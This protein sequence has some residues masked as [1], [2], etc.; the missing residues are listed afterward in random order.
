M[1]VRLR[2]IMNAF[3]R[4]ERTS[5]SVMSE[6]RSYWNSIAAD[7]QETAERNLRLIVD[8]DP[9]AHPPRLALGKLLMQQERTE[10]GVPL[11]TE[12][13]AA[14][15]AEAAFYLGVGCDRSGDLAAALVWME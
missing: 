12:L 14:G 13:A 6:A 15:S 5:Q 4:D 1:K 9:T 7:D 11:L 8:A 10:E 2:K 3:R